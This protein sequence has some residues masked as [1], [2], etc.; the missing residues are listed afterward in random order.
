[1]N[2]LV[3]M[4]FMDAF[5]TTVEIPRWILWKLG[6]QYLCPMLVADLHTDI[7]EPGN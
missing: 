4:F 2:R 3:G 6:C 5:V 1:M 7:L